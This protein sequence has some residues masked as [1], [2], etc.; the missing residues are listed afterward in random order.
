MPVWVRGEERAEIV[1]PFPQPL[2]VTALGNSGATPARGIEAEVVGF[3]SVAR[4]R[5]RRDAAV[6]GR[7]VFVTHEMQPNQDG[8]GY[9]AV[10]RAAPA[11]ARRS[12]RARARPRSSSA[13]SAPTITA[14]RIPASRV[15]PKASRPIPAG[16]LSIPDAE[17]L[18]RISR[19]GAGRC[20]CGS[21]L[22]PRNIGTPPVGQ[23]RRRGA[24][25]RSCGRRD[26]DRRP[27][28]QLGSRHR[29]DRQCRRRRDH[30]RRRAPDHAGGPAAADDPG[31]PVRRRGGRRRRRRRYFARHR[32]DGNVVL[33]G[34][35]DFGADRVWRIELQPRAGQRARS[36]TASRRCSRRSASSAAPTPPMPAPISAPG[37]GGRRRDRPQSGRHPL[38]R[39]SPHARRHA[40]QGRSGAA[41][42]ECRRLD[43]DACRGRQRARAR[44]QP[45]RPAAARR[46][47][48]TRSA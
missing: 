12:P 34:E 30:R 23:R 15:R 27:S 16:A 28:R 11:R 18:Q 21:S 41:A 31:R 5:R 44:S 48:A 4:S 33:V 22:T 9:G 6:R 47:Y 1:S 2:V 7:I 35:S 25:H 46:A 24:G 20:G 10:R 38:F 3:D 45:A 17:Q 42:A 37:R 19:R 39:L 26:R 8:S 13:R 40:R 29:R 43:G 14:T 36:A 32:N